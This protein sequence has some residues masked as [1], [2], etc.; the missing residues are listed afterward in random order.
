[1]LLIRKRQIPLAR[2]A[3]SAAGKGNEAMSRMNSAITKIKSSSDETAKI[4]KTIDEIAFQTN[5]LALNAAVEAARAGEAGKGFAVVA[6]E[7][8]N[9]AQ[10]SAEAAKDTTEL[11]EESQSNANEG[12]SVSTEVAD[13]LSKILQSIEQVT[14]LISEVSSS[15]DEQSQGISQI[16]TSVAEMD[17]VTQ[18]NAASTEESASACEELNSQATELQNI[19]NTL[20]GLIGGARQTEKTSSQTCN[21]KENAELINSK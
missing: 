4:I 17:K 20:K 16:N 7:V 15:G 3:S 1:M 6:E 11:I 2:Q 12:V 18:V 13:I 9:L 19:V 21:E 5:L 10:R 14:N 8:R